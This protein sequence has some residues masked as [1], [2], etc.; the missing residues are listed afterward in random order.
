M[1]GL[2]QVKRLI[3]H[4]GQPRVISLYLDPERFATGPARASQ[5]RSLVDEA[6]RALE[7]LEDRPHDEKVALREALGRIEAFLSSP[8]APFK[9]AR[10]LA[11]FSSG[12]DGL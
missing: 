11:L 10:A 1:S 7:R 6:A 3:S 5:I 12:G 8:E 4:R 9:G 2:E